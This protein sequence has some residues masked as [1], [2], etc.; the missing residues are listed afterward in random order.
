MG[1]EKRR[2]RWIVWT[3]WIVMMSLP[4]DSKKY[5]YCLKSLLIAVPP[6]VQVI[7]F[8]FPEWHCTFATALPLLWPSSGN[9]LPRRKTFSSA[10]STLTISKPNSSRPC[11]YYY[12]CCCSCS[13]PIRLRINT[14]GFP[15]NSPV[16]MVSSNSCQNRVNVRVH[17]HIAWDFYSTGSL[18]QP[19]N[20]INGNLNRVTRPVVCCSTGYAGTTVTTMA[21]TRMTNC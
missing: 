20:T 21:R 3:A 14:S 9:L 7:R 5:L 15:G 2:T 6:S 13:C 10:C 17:G 16:W 18:D 8:I 1:S 19:V 12:Y 4:Q 11:Y